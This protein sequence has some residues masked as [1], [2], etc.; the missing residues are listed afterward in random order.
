MDSK[1]YFT[2]GSAVHI[3]E[4]ILQSVDPS[5]CLCI[6]HQRS[7][8]YDNTLLWLANTGIQLVEFADYGKDSMA[9]L[10]DDDE[11]AMIVVGLS[12]MIKP[13]NRCD[14]R[15]EYMYN[16]AK[17]GRKYV[18]DHV[19]F[20]QEKWRVWYP[21]GLIDP[22][23]LTYPHSYAIESA[24]RNYEEGLVDDDPLTIGWIIDRVKDWTEI[25]YSRYFASD[26]EFI[27]HETT[28]E[29]RQGY[30]ELKARLF[31]TCTTVKPIIA[32]LTKYA[33]EICPERSI[34]VDTRKLYRLQGEA[35][36]HMTDL[37]VDWYLRSEIERVINDTNQLTEGLHETLSQQKRA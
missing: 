22:A 19:P 7:R 36:I 5:K 35:V 27:V 6:Y 32:G 17:V 1:V 37:N 18:I 3:V 9:A 12:D 23:I 11:A 34:F 33:Q 15:F 29:Q 4:Q 26:V 20:L 2:K 16:F 14:I 30:A 13:S 31:D 10:L 25:D 28:P 21:Y 24:Y 8:V